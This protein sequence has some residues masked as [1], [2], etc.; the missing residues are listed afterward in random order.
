M[1]MPLPQLPA[2]PDFSR[3][4]WTVDEMRALPDDGTRYEVIDG[5]LLVMPAPS[6][7]HQRAVLQLALLLAPYV[8]NFAFEAVVAPSEVRFS[9][10][11]VVQPDVFVAPRTTGRSES[12]IEQSE[13]LTLVVEVSSPSSAR[14]DRYKK[15]H[16]YQSERVPEYWIV[17]ADARFVERWRPEDEEPEILI[18]SL[19]W[20]PREDVAALVI[21]LP[22]CF[23]HVHGETEA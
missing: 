5:E 6:R 8:E 11:R 9:R 23:R 21:D 12:Q 17:D 7:V 1:A 19:E 16:L 4:D 10:R 15:R 3:R 14:L 2:L 13:R 20:A 18:D 22:K